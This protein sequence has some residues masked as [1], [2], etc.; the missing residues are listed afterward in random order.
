M[1]LYEDLLRSPLLLLFNTNAS[2][3]FLNAVINKGKL[4]KGIYLDRVPSLSQT[5][6]FQVI[7]GYLVTSRVLSMRY[8]H[9]QADL[10]SLPRVIICIV[11]LCKL[12]TLSRFTFFM[13]QKVITIVS[14]LRGYFKHLIKHLAQT[15]SHK[16]S[17]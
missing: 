16:Y 10:G 5:F 9:S 12:L 1:S 3:C 7:V 6:L 14:T 4:Y 15:L 11:A 17:I 8:I 2:V 13:H